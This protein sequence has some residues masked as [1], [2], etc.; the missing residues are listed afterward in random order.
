[1]TSVSD[2]N[3]LFTSSN[4]SSVGSQQQLSSSFTTTSPIAPFSLV[5]SSSLQDSLD[6]PL[7]RA[8][9]ADIKDFPSDIGLIST[10]NQYL[11][12]MIPGVTNLPPG[13][14]PTTMPETLNDFLQGWVK[15]ATSL[16]FTF[17][18]PSSGGSTLFQSLL[19][20]YAASLGVK[21]DNSAISTTEGDWSILFTS[22]R[23]SIDVELTT[24]SGLFEKAFDQLLKK[25][26][27]QLLVDSSTNRASPVET[28][29]KNFDQFFTPTALLQKPEHAFIAPGVSANAY[30]QLPS[31]EETF[32]ALG[33]PQSTKEQ[34]QEKL[35]EFVT[36]F[37]SKNGA[38]IPGQA[39][40]AWGQQLIQER[41][42]VIPVTP[43]D[44][45]TGSEKTLVFNRILALL[46][47]LIGTIQ[48]SAIAQAN[49]LK[50]HT[51]FQNVYT[52]LQSQ[53][54]VFLKGDANALGADSTNASQLRNELNSSF[55]PQLVDN[56]RAL[57]G[58][59]EDNAKQ[60]QTRLNQSNDAVNQQTDM[61]SSFI[62]QLSTLLTTILR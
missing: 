10:F 42:Q 45:G 50:F 41:N 18:S 3:T 36:D 52:G 8:L 5:P 9:S 27:N 19:S 11:N 29:F 20:T 37:I 31:F 40:A 34:F 46:I 56:L 15:F 44:I 7:F 16:G 21:L 55:N 54:P 30:D 32:F 14:S 51:Q 58:I 2:S 23:A 12:S 62:Q 49:L 28:F 57:R 25:G 6:S 24:T 60:T 17:K 33:P 4:I 22:P 61:V 48:T 53:V 1:M 38:F 26:A 59:S 47:K 39:I 43:V 35:K 13:A